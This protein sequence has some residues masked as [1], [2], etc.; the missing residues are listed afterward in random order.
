MYVLQRPRFSSGRLRIDAAD[1]GGAC[2]AVQCSAMQCNA[3]QCA[4]LLYTTTIASWRFIPAK[5]KT[6][7]GPGNRVRELFSR[8]YKW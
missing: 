5:G 8:E 2:K 3:V 1:D 6:A 7:R 4:C